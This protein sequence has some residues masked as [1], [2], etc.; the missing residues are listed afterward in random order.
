LNFGNQIAEGEKIKDDFS[1][2]I[3]MKILVQGKL[4]VSTNALYFNSMFN[5]GTLFIGNN[6]K[7][8]VPLVDIKNIAK[9]TNAVIFDN[10][11]EIKL[12][13]GSTIFITSF[14]NRNECYRLILKMIKRQN[15]SV[16]QHDGDT[17]IP[18][19]TPK[20]TTVS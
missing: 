13:N 3:Q 14:L 11:I 17:Q 15:L 10:S 16:L 1:A 9:K 7:I 20:Y 18:R 5:D 8:K 6:T 19:K 2:A 4:Y 12:K